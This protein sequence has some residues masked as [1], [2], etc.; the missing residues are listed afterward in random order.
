MFMSLCVC[1]V[2]ANGIAWLSNT[3]QL[4]SPMTNSSNLT[5]LK[6]W[7]ADTYFNLAMGM[8]VVVRELM[9]CI[10][11]SCGR[12]ALAV[13]TVERCVVLLFF[14]MIMLSLEVETGG[15]L[16]RHLRAHKTNFLCFEIKVVSAKL[17]YYHR[18]AHQINLKVCFAQELVTLELIPNIKQFMLVV[19]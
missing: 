18:I 9:H 13:V 10:S 15:G 4:C 2:T 3:F 19:G 5:V 7:L 14:A 16:Q 11:W 17:G 6:S 1:V 8:I 12:S